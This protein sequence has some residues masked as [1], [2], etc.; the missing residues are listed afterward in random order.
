MSRGIVELILSGE[1]D[2]SP[3]LPETQVINI[4]LGKAFDVY[5]GRAEFAIDKRKGSDG[6]YGNPHHVGHCPTCKLTHARGEAVEAFKKGFLV[7]IAHDPEFRHR[8]EEL[9]GKK[10]GCFCGAGRCHC[11]VYVWWLSSNP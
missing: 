3:D 10:L 4:K 7:R 9:R 6:Y 11:D 8:V 1:P 2:D 5:C